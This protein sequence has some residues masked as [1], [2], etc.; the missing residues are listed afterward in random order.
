MYFPDRGCVHPLRHCVHVQMDGQ[1]E[2]ILPPDLSV[3]RADAK[4]RRRHHYHAAA[5]YHE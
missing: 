4:E 1:A 3:R 5:S 2:N